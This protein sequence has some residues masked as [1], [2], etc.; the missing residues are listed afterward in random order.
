MLSCSATR[1]STS[2]SVTDDARCRAPTLPQLCQAGRALAAADHYRDRPCRRR[3]TTEAE[4]FDADYLI[5]ALGADYDMERPRGWPRPT[6]SIRERGRAPARCA[7]HLHQ[8]KGAHRG[9]RRAVQMPA[10]AQRM[11]L[12]AARLPSQSRRARG[13]RDQLRAAVGQS[14][15][16]LAGNLARAGGGF[17]RARHQIRSR[18]PRGVAR[19]RPQGRNSR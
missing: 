6:N 11:R 9:L 17:H 14:G 5:V 12:D 4:T 13:L 3:V 15:A 18:P 16:A 19:L 7:A 10:G 2:C 1:S 8:G